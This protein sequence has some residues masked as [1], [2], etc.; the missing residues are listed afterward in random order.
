MANLRQTLDTIS[1]VDVGGNDFTLQ[2]TDVQP[3]IDNPEI[4]QMEA[5]IAKARYGGSSIQDPS[6]SDPSQGVEPIGVYEGQAPGQPKPVGTAAKP[7]DFSRRGD[8]EFH[9]F[10]QLKTENM[11]DGNPFNFDPNAQLNKISKQDLPQLFER[12]FAGEVSWQDR[13]LLDDDQKKY[14][15][16]EVKRYRAH[17]ETGLKGE[18]AQAIDSYN[19]MMNSFD[20]AAKEQ[21]AKNKQQRENRKQIYEAKIEAL[22]RSNK[23]QEKHQSQVSRKRELLTEQ[24]ELMA[25]YQ[26]AETAGTLTPEIS[27]ARLAE[28]QAISDELKIINA[29]LKTFQ[30]PNPRSGVT[31]V[32]AK[33]NPKK[34]EVEPEKDADGKTIVRKKIPAQGGDDKKPLMHNGKAVA[35]TGTVKKGPNKGRKKNNLHRREFR[36]CRRR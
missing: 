7:V 10:N 33:V 34:R 24:R 21:A 16:S 28:I 20:N 36:I 15:M 23:R 32:E 19:Q 17:V 11:P 12:S 29:D 5:D 30:M 27:Q 2:E 4:A 25:E 13:H 1:G 8:F 35:K 26:D 22:E 9:V 6:P 3:Y 18:R 31:K 14:W